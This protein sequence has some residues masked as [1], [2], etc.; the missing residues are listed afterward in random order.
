MTRSADN[1]APRVLLVTRNFPPLRGGMERLTE[2]MFGCIR[3]W[4]PESALVGP[5]GCGRFVRDTSNVAE[6]V[7]GP[8]PAT[9]LS[10][11]T[12]GMAMARRTRPDVV[13]AGSGLAAPAAV[14]AAG[15]VGAVPAV[16][17]HGLDIVA[18][19]PVYRLGWLP[20][21][22]RCRHV[23]A[24][25]SNTRRLAIEAGVD[26]DR[27]RVV[28]PGTD[29][30]PADPSARA[31]FRARHCIGDDAPVLLSVGRLTARKGLAEFVDLCLPRLVEKHPGLRLVVVGDQAPDALNRGDGAGIERVRGAAHKHGI[32]MALQWLGS[33][34]DA[35]LA[36]AYQAADVHVFPVRDMPGDVEG[37]G[38]VAIEAAANGLFTVA[39]DVGGVRDAIVVGASG[40]LVSAGDY[41]GFAT[42]VLDTLRQAPIGQSAR[43]R[44]AVGRFSWERFGRE[45]REA[46]VAA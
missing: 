35:E 7:P 43:A 21:I 9:L 40:T 17:L 3:A 13:L 33:C 34:T 44:A 27:I 19:N 4:A 45:M 31:R 5:A 26:A 36:E 32:T 12:R 11:V 14:M 8:L 23:I 2:R 24:N 15:I 42:E 6:L 37:F 25:S 46:L 41:K 28:H 1:Q 10:S 22:R 20:F 30:P 29:S 18:A 38:M 39:F 16:Y